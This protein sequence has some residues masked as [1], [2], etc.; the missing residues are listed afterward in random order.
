MFPK[1]LIDIWANYKRQWR[2]LIVALVVVSYIACIHNFSQNYTFQ[3][4]NMIAKLST[5]ASLVHKCMHVCSSSCSWMRWRSKH[6]FTRDK[7]LQ[8]WFKSILKSLLQGCFTPVGSTFGAHQS[9]IAVFSPSQ[10]EPHKGVKLTVVQ[11]KPTEWV[12][13]EKPLGCFIVQESNYSG[14][15]STSWK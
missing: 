9:E 2:V 12:R 6:V 15:L 3:E 4:W 11:F 7:Q 8:S 13:C 14:W 1:L 5:P 10:N